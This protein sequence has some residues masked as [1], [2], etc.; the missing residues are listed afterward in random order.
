MSEP[1]ES[2]ENAGYMKRLMQGTALSA[3][4]FVVILA[5]SFWIAPIQAHTLGDRLNGIWLTVAT[6]TGWYALLDFG[7]N[8]TVSRFVTKSFSTKD[9]DECNIFISTGFGLFLMMGGI[10]IVLALIFGFGAAYFFPETEDIGLLGAVIILSGAAFALDFPLRAFTGISLGTMRHDLVGLAGIFFRVAGAVTTYLILVMGGRLIALS[11]GNIVLALAQIW[12]YYVLARRSFPQLHIS[13]K[14]MR[15][16]YVGTLLNY[17]VFGFIAH[18]G[19]TFIFQLGKLIIPILLAFEYASPYGYAVMFAE[20]FRGLL[21]ALT[22][23][24][25]TWLTYLHT[26]GLKDELLKTMR[27]GF[28]FCTYV[29]GFI[30]FGLIAWSDPFITRWMLTPEAIESGKISLVY[31]HDIVPC[32]ILLTLAA[33]VRTVQE[34]NIRYLYA[35]ANHHYYAFSNIVEG[36]LNVE[37]SVI[38]ALHYGLVGFA[39]GTLI[40]SVVLR[41]FYIPLITCRLMETRLIAFYGYMLGLF[42]L[43]GIALV[44]PLIVT[45]KL[46]APNYPALFLVGGIS[47]VTYFPVIYRIGFSPEERRKIAGFVFKRKGG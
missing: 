27:F 6:L 5:L 7:L 47:A 39:M 12:T 33:A 43:V 1:S 14:N 26:Q 20:H 42:L 32:V 19:N 13:R 31:W 38:F 28:K 36:L 24:M 3:I 41:G 44:V 21:M 34:P 18:I 35:T 11:L 45:M 15:R 4:N 10:V 40:A 2:P 25:V 9:Y 37:L 46:A 8:Y 17:S 29:S 16:S 23:W 30:A 22:N